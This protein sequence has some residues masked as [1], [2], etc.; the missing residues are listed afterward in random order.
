MDKIPVKPIVVVVVLIAVLAL[1]VMLQPTG[2]PDDPTFCEIDSDCHLVEGCCG[3][4]H[5]LNVAYNS[6]P[7]EDC[8]GIACAPPRCPWE[9]YNV[10]REL[11]KQNT[12][13]ECAGNEYNPRIVCNGGINWE[14]ICEGLCDFYKTRNCIIEEDWCGWDEYCADYS[15]ECFEE[16]TIREKYDK[17]IDSCI[18]AATDYEACLQSSPVYK[19]YKEWCESRGGS[20][21][22]IG[23][24]PAAQCNLPTSDGGEECDDGSDCESMCLVELT[25]EQRAEYDENGI[26]TG[27]KGTCSEYKTVVGCWPVIEEGTVEMEICID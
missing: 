9:E 8:Q 3:N 5:C 22:Y 23:L 19:E 6:P 17:L 14:K 12:Y 1:L 18:I 26:I 13:C 21:G 27:I 15:C 2:N 25:D 7:G 20:F 16:E 4:L 24:F 10:V 11:T